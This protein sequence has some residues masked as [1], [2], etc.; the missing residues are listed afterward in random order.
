LQLTDI[1]PPFNFYNE[2]QRI[3]TRARYLPA[4]KV[5]GATIHHAVIADG[6]IINNATLNRVM[7][8]VRSVITE[9]SKLENVVMMGADD[10]ENDT[11]FEENV[12][13]GRPNIGVGKGCSIRNAILDK[14]VR[15]GNNV[16]LDPAG[17]E[18]NFESGVD[19]VIRD[20]VLIVTKDTVLLDGFQMKA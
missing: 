20:G 7:L 13:L 14:N 15:I 1:K 17:L 8:G 10:F 5:N 12:A 19:V 16:V 2:T 18:D 3:Y 6:S 9:G 11:D 4:V